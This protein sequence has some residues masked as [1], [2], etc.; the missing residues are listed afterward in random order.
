MWCW[1]ANTYGQVGNGLGTGLQIIPS[2]VA[3][4]AG[5]VEIDAGDE[6][7]C[8]RLAGGELR[9]WGQNFHG[10]LGDGSMED[11]DTPVAALD[12]GEAI[13]L[14]CGSVHTCARRAGGQPW[15]WGSNGSGR[16]GTDTTDGVQRRPTATRFACP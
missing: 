5:V 4:L 2:K 13:E 14:T 3:G 6:F 16:T 12:F 15:C 1:G 8:A 10:Q 9:C 11:R 7:S